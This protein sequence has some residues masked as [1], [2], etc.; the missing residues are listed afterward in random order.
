[1]ITCDRCLTNNP[2]VTTMSKFNTQTICMACKDCECAHA[3]YKKACDAEEADLKRTLAARKPNYFAGIGLPA[4]IR[5]TMVDANM[6][7]D[8]LKETFVDATWGHHNGHFE[9]L[10]QEELHTREDV[11]DLCHELIVRYSDK[12]LRVSDSSE[13][14][15]ICIRCAPHVLTEIYRMLREFSDSTN[16]MLSEVIP[17]AAVTYH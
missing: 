11:C 2:P 8:G 4:D 9:I 7:S 10:T 14:I 16:V 6:E 13:I 15:Q 3:S 12:Y 17:I 5:K 1:M